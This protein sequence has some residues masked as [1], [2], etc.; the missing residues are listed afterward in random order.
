MGTLPGQVEDAMLD[1]YDLVYDWA[2][3]SPSSARRQELV[4]VQDTV[5]VEGSSGP[6]CLPMWTAV[7]KMGSGW[8][9]VSQPGPGAEQG[10]PGQR[11]PRDKSS[12]L[13]PLPWMGLLLN[14]WGPEQNKR[15]LSKKLLRIA[16]R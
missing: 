15:P 4:A 8:P 13:L 6:V 7:Q 12:A 16:S 10:V 9:Q 14:L 11:C 3:R 1:T 5:S 2:L